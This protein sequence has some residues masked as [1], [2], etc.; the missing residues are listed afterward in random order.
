MSRTGA[1]ISELPRR[2]VSRR[3]AKC[4]RLLVVKMLDV[5]TMRDVTHA[6][7]I[8]AGKGTRADEGVPGD[9]VDRIV[10]QWARERPDLDTGAM[11]IFGR[12]FQL[13]RLGGD[14]V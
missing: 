10:A 6:E 8:S 1:R 4:G 11:A 2:K 7:D 9:G 5:E 14:R 13:A 3:Q 12:I